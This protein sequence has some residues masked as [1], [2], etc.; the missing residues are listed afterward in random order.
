MNDDGKTK[1]QLLEELALLRD[2]V[3]ELEGAAGTAPGA[4]IKNAY[5]K[6]KS[7][8]FKLDTAE[9]RHQVRSRLSSGSVS[10]KFLTAYA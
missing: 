4:G 7:P 9:V 6:R 5:Q 8:A 10:I 3:A 2:K 1:R